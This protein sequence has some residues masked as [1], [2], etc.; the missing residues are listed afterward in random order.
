MA[1]VVQSRNR[2]EDK[3]KAKAQGARCCV[4]KVPEKVERELRDKGRK[5]KKKK[6]KK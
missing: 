1:C 2:A 6:E 5:N 4:V 3:D